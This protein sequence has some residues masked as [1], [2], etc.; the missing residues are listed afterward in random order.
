MKKSDIQNGN[1][2]YKIHDIN[3]REISLEEQDYIKL[4]YSK[5][6]YY[7][8]NLEAKLV[9]IYSK[10]PI[11]NMEKKLVLPFKND[12]FND[13]RAEYNRIIKDCFKEYK[14]ISDV[15]KEIYLVITG[16]TEFDINKINFYLK[17]ANIFIEQVSCI[18]NAANIGG[19]RY[20][21]NFVSPEL[22]ENFI[23]LFETIDIEQKSIEI[24]LNPAI[25]QNYSTL[26]NTCVDI[27]LK[28]KSEANLKTAEKDLK[29]ILRRLNITYHN[30]SLFN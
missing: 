27:E 2:I 30:N 9:I 26:Y 15:K 16:E 4:I 8:K 24:S 20:N 22:F 21:L 14:Y 23:S 5:L 17:E 12:E 25:K 18:E 7:I 29:S 19:I 6:L 1:L 28:D 3:Y 11:N 10:M 13:Y